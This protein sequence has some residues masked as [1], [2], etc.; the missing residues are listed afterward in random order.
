M[1]FFARVLYAATLTWKK[2]ENA[3][4]VVDDR[5]RASFNILHHGYLTAAYLGALVEGEKAD[6]IVRCLGTSLL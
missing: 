1:Q 3:W 6:D 4:Q 2:I 5:Q